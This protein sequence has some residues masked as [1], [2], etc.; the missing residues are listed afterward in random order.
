MSCDVC[1]NYYW[2]HQAT[3]SSI[4]RAGSSN[5]KNVAIRPDFS[6]GLTERWIEID[7]LTG[8][9]AGLRFDIS[10]IQHLYKLLISFKS[11]LT[12]SLIFHTINTFSYGVKFI[13]MRSFV[14]I[15]ISLV[16]SINALHIRDQGICGEVNSACKS[17]AATCCNEKSGFAVCK[18]GKVV[19]HACDEHSGCGSVAGKIQCIKNP[20][21]SPP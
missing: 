15:I 8:S 4:Y 12:T 18:G 2:T 14:V 21:I 10:V 16:A 6:T 11:S 5:L 17:G 9:L 1:V 20:S 3:L 7:S 19:F 13:K